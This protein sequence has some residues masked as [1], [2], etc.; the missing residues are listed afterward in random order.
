MSPASPGARGRLAAAW[1]RAGDVDPLALALRLGLLTLVLDASL[2]WFERVPLAAVAAF[3]LLMP[4]AARQRALWAAVLALTVAPLAWD[5]PFSDNHAYLKALFPLAVLCALSC[6]DPRAALATSARLLVGGTFLFATLW[7]LVLS[8]DF[9]DGTFFRVTLLTDG[10]FANVAVLAGGLDADQ[11]YA[12]DDALHD[13][14][15]GEVPWEESGF[16]EP[17]ELARLACVA[18]VFTAL[19]EAG[20]A[21]AFLWPAGRGPS[22]AR[23][24]LLLL[25]ALATYPVA[26]VRGFGWLLMTLGVAQTAP[27]QRGARLAY[28][29]AW[30]AVE[31][32]RSVPWDDALVAALGAG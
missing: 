2:H 22:R 1:R 16:V 24:P 26:T 30:F 4:G 6:P 3:G 19:V 8:P 21:L 25:F 10:R 9:L 13:T 32:F 20:I 18:T 29:A 28:L 17:P 11:W 27:R 15:A 31:A 23:N 14:L 12:N 7:K 5:W